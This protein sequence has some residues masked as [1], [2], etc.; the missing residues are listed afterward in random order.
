MLAPDLSVAEYGDKVDARMKQALIEVGLLSSLGD[1]R[2]RQYF[3][4][5]LVMASELMCMTR[6][7][8]QNISNQTWYLL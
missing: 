1:E 7:A 8:D 4:M 3:P 5:R 2:Y 6:S